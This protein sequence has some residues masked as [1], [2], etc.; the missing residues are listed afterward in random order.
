MTQDE[1]R[2]KLERKIGFIEN[3]DWEGI[4]LVVD[5]KCYHLDIDWRQV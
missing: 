3:I 5:G 2:E 4:D 1:A